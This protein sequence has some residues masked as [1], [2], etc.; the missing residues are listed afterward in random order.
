MSRRSALLATLL[1][2]VV[3]LAGL[4]VFAIPPR[5]SA[6]GPLAPPSQPSTA[7]AGSPTP[8]PT[9][10]PTPLLT[11]PAGAAHEALDVAVAAFWD[12]PSGTFWARSD[13]QL[14]PGRNTQAFFWWPAHLWLDALDALAASHSQADRDLVAGMYD[15]VDAH[16]PGFVNRYYDD[17]AWWALGMARAYELTGDR[18]YLVHGD[19]L[20]TAIWRG[21]D[22]ALGGGLWW[23]KTARDEKNM[24]TNA[25]AVEAAALFARLGGAGIDRTRAEQGFAWLDGTLRHGDTLD[26]KVLAS[27][28]PVGWQLTY[29]YGAYI[30]AAVELSRL[31][32]AGPYLERATSLAAAA[33]ARFAPGG[34][35][36]PNE[37]VGDAG[38]FKGILVRA[39]AL[40]DSVTGD[41]RYAALRA[42]NAKAAWDHRGAAGL[43]GP[44]WQTAPSGAVELLAAASGVA[45]LYAAP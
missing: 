15:A 8:D 44:D 3:A 22:G 11:L 28:R 7:R 41:G 43:I 16:V 4:A 14:G 38:A 34:G 18:R 23:R 30:A 1:V 13:H 9:P 35:V 21:W 17:M 37:G 45:A 27:G 31:E 10:S 42:V 12:R 24:V 26:D 2:A 25:T 36:L 40:V 5:S 6:S 29:D 33:A 19:Q 32:P 39:L 20:L